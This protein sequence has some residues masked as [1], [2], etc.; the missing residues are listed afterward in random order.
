MSIDVIPAGSSVVVTDDDNYDNDCAEIEAIKDAEADLERSGGMHYGNLVGYIKDA[1]ADAV[2]TTKDME[3]Q[4]ARQNG[5]AY[6]G[7]LETIK[8][9]EVNLNWQAGDRFIQLIQD[10]K[11][12]EAR[13]EKASGDRFIWTMQDIKSAQ[14][15]TVKGT[16][17]VVEHQ[18]DSD[19]RN[20]KGFAHTNER[21][22]DGFKEVLEET[23]EW[24][25]DLKEV[26]KDNFKETQVQQLLQFKEQALISERT[27]CKQELLSERLAA[28][29][30]AQLAECCCELKEL[31]KDEAAETRE[32]IN[33]QEV[34]RLRE[35]ARKAEA[36]VAAYFSAKVA[37]VTPIL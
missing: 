34:D 1:E 4:M 35:R 8:D 33:A 2:K 31:V 16:G 22:G 11:D 23:S 18:K 19:Y 10:V 36:G 15:D 27:A 3:A 26:V 5:Q 6:A 13:T 37:P 21:L 32:L 30:A 25:C 12:L 29:A 28:Q 9:S 14:L 17:K 20:A 7:T 24:L